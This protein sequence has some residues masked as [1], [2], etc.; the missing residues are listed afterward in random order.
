MFHPNDILFEDNHLIVVN[1]RCGDLVQPD[2]N[3]D[4]ALENE[5]KAFIKARDN[6]PFDVFLGVVHRI[7]RPVSGV[8]LFAKTSKALARMNEMIRRGEI[9]KRYWAV[10]EN[11]PESESGELV[12]YILRDGKSNRSYC[13]N[14][15]KGD[16]KR[17]V[18]MLGHPYIIIGMARERVV[19]IDDDVK[20]LPCDGIYPAVVN[21]IATEIAID[22]R[23]IILAARYDG[24]VVIEL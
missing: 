6:K 5:I 15:P 23:T 14:A 11:R 2:P 1:K 3:G 20:Q 13:Y 22:N 19:T 9:S 24:R 4:S 18:A 21:G 7:D 8:V 10:V 12:H 17:A 16:A